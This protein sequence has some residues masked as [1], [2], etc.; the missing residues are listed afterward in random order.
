ML[1]TGH[2]SLSLGMTNVHGVWGIEYNL[3]CMMYSVWYRVCIDVVMKHVCMYVWVYY[4]IASF[5]YIS[6]LFCQYPF[7]LHAE[8]RFI[9]NTYNFPLSDKSEWG[10]AEDESGL[11]L[12]VQKYNLSFV[13]KPFF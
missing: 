12:Y 13:S 5:I 8:T 6:S 3:W 2:L 7:C 1:E 9:L 10:K 4:D 11:V